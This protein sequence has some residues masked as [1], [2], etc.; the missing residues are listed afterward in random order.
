MF[1]KNFLL[2]LALVSGSAAGNL[3]HLREPSVRID[4][5]DEALTVEVMSRFHSWMEFHGKQYDDHD[6]KMK[7]LYTWMENDYKIEEHNNQEP[8]PSYTLGHNEYS[9]MTLDEFHRHFKLGEYSQ[10][11]PSTPTKALAVEDDEEVQK[12]RTLLEGDDS[13]DLPDYVNW[14]GMGAVTPVKNQGFCGACW[15]FSTTGALEGAKFLRT[16]E[17]VSLSEQNLLDCDHTDM[18]CNG[19][20]MDNAFKFDEKSGGLCS[21]ADYPYEAKQGSCNTNCTDVAGSIVK[22]FLD[23]P[24]GKEKA[25]LSAIALQP[26]SVAIQANQMAFQFYKN[27][28]IVDTTCGSRGNLDH[29]VLAVGYGTDL[30]TQEPYFLVKNSWGETWG[31]AGYVRIGRNMTNEWGI[32]AITKMAS[33]PVVDF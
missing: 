19:G 12:L 26:I 7:R 33:F 16:G 24:P 13:L 30:E 5:V 10:G 6:V 11:P 9:D 28:V 17:L 23:V 32:C 31:E 4:G 25:L 20:L 18:G 27:G 22:T 29:G 21:E 2:I 1:S 14:I 3:D 15:A 8:K